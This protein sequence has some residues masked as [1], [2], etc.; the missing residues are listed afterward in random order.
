M[1]GSIS[2]IVSPPDARNVLVLL[3]GI[4]QGN[5]P[6][7][8]TV[9]VGKHTVETRSKDYLPETKY[10]NVEENKNKIVQFD[11]LSYTG[12]MQQEIDKWKTRKIVSGL[13]ILL[14]SATS[15]YFFYQAEQAFTNYQNATSTQTALDQKE[16]VKANELYTVIALGVGGISAIEYVRSSIK[17]FFAISKKKRGI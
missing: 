10:V 14:S 9:P 2:V 13:S 8:I 12:S 5:A 15:G 7:V 3:D 6:K 4:E 17:K 1:K 16:A 11:L